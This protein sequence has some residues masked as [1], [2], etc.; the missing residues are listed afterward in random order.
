MYNLD[1]E[2]APELT[3]GY[4][5]KGW[6]DATIYSASLKNGTNRKGNNYQYI[7]IDFA[8]D[9]K[10]APSFFNHRQV[11]TRPDPDLWKVLKAVGLTSGNY[12][13]NHGGF[14]NTLIGKQLQVYVVHKYPKRVRRDRAIDFRSLLNH[15]TEF[16]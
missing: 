4:F 16:V 1:D 14:F 8:I 7:I 2:R 5:L 9:N 11:Q 15:E 6:H 13:G 10:L 12:T 3:Y